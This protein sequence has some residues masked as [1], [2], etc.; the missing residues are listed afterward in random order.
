MT[1]SEL[2]KNILN[3]VKHCKKMIK[4]QVLSDEYF[5]SYSDFKLFKSLGYKKKT[6]NAN[7]SKTMTASELS[8]VSYESASVFVSDL[9]KI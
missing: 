7:I 1:A 2:K 8:L 4:H 3:R 5:R 9:K 6:G